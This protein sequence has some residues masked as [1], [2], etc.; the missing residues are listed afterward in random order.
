MKTLTITI[1][2]YNVEQYLPEVL[3][4][5][6]NSEVLEDIEILIVND[7]S[8]DK[9]AEIAQDFQEK[10][11]NTVRL[12]NK[13]NGGHGS[14]INTGIAN[15]NGKYFRVIDGDDWVDTDAFL[16][17]VKALKE[18]DTDLVLT[19]F[20]RVYIDS[21]KSEIN[22]FQGIEY[23]HRYLFDDIVDYLDDYYAIH[24]ATFLTDVIR[25]IPRISEHCFYVDQEYVCY[26][27][28]YISTVV[29]L[30]E[31]VYQYRLGSST[32]SVSKE[33]KIKNRDMHRHVTNNIVDLYLK[34]D[35]SA[36]KHR[37]LYQKATG[38]I[39]YLMLIYMSMPV[40]G[41]AQKEIKSF[42]QEIDAKNNTLFDGVEGRAIGWLHRSR[43]ALYYPTELLW[44]VKNHE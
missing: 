5:Y 32:Q 4:T 40:S 22:S 26:A 20:N 7:G 23:G 18:I 17:Y 44:K 1:P 14:T 43:G 10:Y 6:L 13:E 9:T 15:A 24:S 8:K 42:I 31:V 39:R 21:G 16:S 25:K 12:I 36:S 29:F 19:P 41:E 2:S 28:P 3:P 33:S 11:P 27:V 37:L 30:D 34:A 35:V 38:M